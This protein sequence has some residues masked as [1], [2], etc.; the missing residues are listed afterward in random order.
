M[1][2]VAQSG[3]CDWL[4]QPLSKRAPEDARPLKLSGPPLSPATGSTGRLSL[5]SA[6]VGDIRHPGLVALRDGWRTQR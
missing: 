2:G 6:D 3:Y 5:P 4:K 1:L